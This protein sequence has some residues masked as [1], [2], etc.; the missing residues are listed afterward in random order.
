MELDPKDDNVH[1][2]LGIVLDQVNQTEQAMTEVRRALELAQAELDYRQDIYTYDAL[3]WALYKNKRYDE[4]GKALEKA[5]RLS[6][7]E[8][9]FQE[10]GRKI[11]AAIKPEVE[12]PGGQE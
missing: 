4:A 5:V 2:Q 8:P 3:A 1:L 7:P 10:H 11:A 12:K 6:T 9:M